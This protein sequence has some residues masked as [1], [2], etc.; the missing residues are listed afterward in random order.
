MLKHSMESIQLKICMV[1]PL[2]PPYGG[3]AN[4]YSLISKYVSEK[5]NIVFI[6][7][8]NASKSQR[9]K[10]SGVRPLF[11][12]IVISGFEL[13]SI[14]NAF[15]EIVREFNP[16]VVHIT[17]SG[18]L[19]IIRDIVLL[20]YAKRKGIP[21][22]YHIRFGR[23]QDIS[24]RDTIE[25]RMLKYA[26]SK[27]DITIAIDRATELSLVSECRN[28][29]IRYIPNPFDIRIIENI[30]SSSS[31][32][33]RIV[34]IGWVIKTKGIEE[35][36]EAWDNLNEVSRHY[37][38]EIIGPG[39]KNY[40]TELNNKY[41]CNN[42]EFIGE[43]NHDDVLNR[44]SVAKAL[45]LPSYTEGFP[46]SVLEAMALRIPVIAT[47]VGAIPEMLADDCGFLI[48]PK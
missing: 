9:K 6:P 48:E 25:W 42:V 33:K 22:V 32:R 36:L 47:S 34:F 35:L 12:R 37:S 10:K 14:R 44:L 26:V 46:N 28:A 41:F 2:P 19:A 29:D 38:L 3:I 5:K 20:R 45:I 18:Q 43:L 15:Y 8:N 1:V 30:R 27:A 4:W 31:K 21:S 11:D 13:F 23:V 17:T 7:L 16:D 40:I 24:K 39:E